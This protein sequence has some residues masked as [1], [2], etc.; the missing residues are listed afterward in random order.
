MTEITL[1][2]AE[3][4]RRAEEHL[5]QGQLA[6]AEL[7]LARVLQVRPDHDPAITAVI[8]LLQR[9][10]RISEAIAFCF[11]LADLRP[12]QLEPL[13]LASDLAR[14]FCL[15]VLVDEARTRLMQ[16]IGLSPDPALW[17][18]LSSVVYRSLFMPFPRDAVAAME[19][20]IDQGVRQ[21]VASQGGP[22]PPVAVE[23]QSEGQDRPLRI[24]YLSANFNNHPIGHVTLSLFEQHD[25]QRFTVHGFWRR[26]AQ[27]YD[28]YS[29]R[30]L[31][32]FDHNHDISGLSPADAAR[33]IRDQA[34]DILVALDGHMDKA[35]LE[36]LTFRP[37]VRQIYWLGHAGG[38]G[39]T[40]V[41]YLIADRIVVPSG[42]EP[43]YREQ[44][45]RLPEIYHC[46]DRLTV[47]GTT[48]DRAS[49]G[50]PP[51]GAVFCGFNSPE[52]ID[53][54]IFAS[55]MRILNRVPG[56]VLWLS[57]PSNT[58]QREASFR[59][60]AERAGIAAGRILFAARIADKAAHLARHRHATVFLDTITL[61]ASTTALDA[62]LAGLPII[63]L[64]GDTFAGR[65]AES[66]LTAAGLPEMVVDT[67]A[68][69]EDRAVEIANDPVLAKSL[70]HRLNEGLATNP[71]F[72][73]TR[74]CRHLEAAYLTLWQQCCAGQPVSGFDVPALPEPASER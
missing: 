20:A 32:G 63:S 50:L 28:S 2:I 72:N 19:R 23:R 3:A 17:R 4:V 57:N 52:K 73:T 31:R 14:S 65:I 43:L 13:I 6:Q 40:S 24:G 59:Q 58:P 39:L 26:P 5:T 62:L 61:T 74:F 11:R 64:R 70:R 33:L 29:Q 69:Y 9:Q 67:L 12:T 8:G 60:A 30:H 55:W 46:A 54:R 48:D 27:A 1:T 42:E 44:I 45:I 7:I 66:M 10:Y 34:I 51:D 15:F 25:R 36:I 49:H 16:R 38:L 47:A 68:A 21:H 18:Q 37:A 56:S 35:A 22:L 53:G 41:D 71:L